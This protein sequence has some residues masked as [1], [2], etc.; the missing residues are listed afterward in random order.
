MVPVARRRDERPAAGGRAGQ[1]GAS[2]AV[3]GDR[4]TEIEG[5]TIKPV[6][7]AMIARERSGAKNCTARMAR[8]RPLPRGNPAPGLLCDQRFASLI[9]PKLYAYQLFLP[10]LLDPFNSGV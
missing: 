2:K 3:K 5:Q 6:K 8:Q 1:E 10:R 7:R 4:D 9:Q